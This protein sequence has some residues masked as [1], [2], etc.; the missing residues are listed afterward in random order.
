MG[1]KLMVLVLF[2]CSMLVQYGPSAADFEIKLE[3]GSISSGPHQAADLS[4]LFEFLYAYVAPKIFSLPP[5]F[6][7]PVKPRHALLISHTILIRMSSDVDDERY[8]LTTIG[9]K[10]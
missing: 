5:P 4:D 7:P 3:D 2:L 6:G 9:V 8:I 1:L 10:K